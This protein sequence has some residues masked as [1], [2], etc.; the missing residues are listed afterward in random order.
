[1]SAL[2]LNSKDRLSFAAR[3]NALQTLIGRYSDG[4]MPMGL[5]MEC[6][7]LK[8]GV[9]VGMPSKRFSAQRRYHGLGTTLLGWADTGA[10]MGIAEDWIERTV[11]R[12]QLSNGTWNTY[13]DSASP[14]LN[15]I[16]PSTAYAVLALT[17]KQRRLPF[18]RP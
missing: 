11:V 10:T 16:T 13:G 5:E 3:I 15:D 1:M 18:L 7:K 4:P 12:S 14:C 17:A 6:L 8:L 9:S 2:R